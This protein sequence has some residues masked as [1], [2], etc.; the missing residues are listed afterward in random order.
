MNQTISRIAALSLLLAPLALIARAQTSEPLPTAQPTPSVKPTKTPKPT[1]T[2]KPTKAPKPTATPE[3]TPTTTTA[4]IPISATDGDD[5]KTL[6]VRRGGLIELRL[7]SNPSTGY[8]WFVVSTTNIKQEGEAAYE[9]SP[10]AP[11]VVG[12][13]GFSVFRFRGV[14]NGTGDLALDLRA[15]GY[16]EGDAPAKTFRAVVRVLK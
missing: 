15:P 3:P 10:V 6:F 2:P 12:S 1:R 4:P 11:G 13:G 16:K 8:G 7:A 5:G 14:K 9:A